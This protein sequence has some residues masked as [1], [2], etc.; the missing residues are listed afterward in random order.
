M[1]VKLNG[2]KSKECLIVLSHGSSHN[3]GLA[4]KDL[5]IKL[6]VVVWKY[7]IMGSLYSWTLNWDVEQGSTNCLLAKSSQPLSL[8]GLQGKMAFTFLN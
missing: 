7:G 8:F 6:I 5:Q 4:E 3:W 1:W 2:F